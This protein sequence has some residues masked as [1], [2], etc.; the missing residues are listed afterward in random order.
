MWTVAVKRPTDMSNAPNPRSAC[1]PQEYYFVKRESA[2]TLILFKII[3]Y[4]VFRLL[5]S[6]WRED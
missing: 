6:Q 4:V 2:I 1:S 5:Q 3:E